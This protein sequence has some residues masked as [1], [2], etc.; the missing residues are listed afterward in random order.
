MILVLNY[1]DVF[2]IFKMSDWFRI[3]IIIVMEES[4]TYIPTNATLLQLRATH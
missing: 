1:L 4:A 3:N 2:G